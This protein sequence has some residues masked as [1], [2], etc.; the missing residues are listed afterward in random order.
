MSL[1]S[2]LLAHQKHNVYLGVGV[3]LLALSTLLF[4]GVSAKASAADCDNNSIISCGESS[5]SAFI[6]Q[7]KAND[8]KN[9]TTA[10][11]EP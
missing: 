11:A 3:L 4:G 5:P 2:R 1:A 7:I 9:T 8:S 6:A 10:I